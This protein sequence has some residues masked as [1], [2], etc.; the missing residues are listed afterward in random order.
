VAY[1]LYPEKELCNYKK[2][3]MK[4]RDNVKIVEISQLEITGAKP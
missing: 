2:Y 1:N 3:Q 4:K